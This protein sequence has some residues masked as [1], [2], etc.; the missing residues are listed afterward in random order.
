MKSFVRSCAALATT[1]FLAHCTNDAA[2]NPPPTAVPEAGVPSPAEDAGGAEASTPAPPVP[3]PKKANIVFILADDFTWNLVQYMPN[4]L[5]MQ[6]DGLTFAN[7]FV[8]D[9]LCCPSRTSIL[10]GMYPHDSGVFTNGG[11]DG[12]Y[13]TFLAKGNEQ[14]TF[15]NALSSTGY[16]TA[17]MGKYLNG[18]DPLSPAVPAGWTEWAG[19]GPGYK[20]FDY[21]LNQS[22]TVHHYGTAD[23]DYLT[24]VV[25]GLGGTF[26]GKDPGKP[27]LLEIAT[28]TP[29][30][31]YTPAPRDADA[32]PGLKAPRTSSYGAR[33]GPDAPTWLKAIPALTPNVEDKMDAAFRKRAQSV[34][35]IDKM[36]GTLRAAVAAAGQTDNTYFVF[37][38][39]NGYHMGEHSLRPGKQTAFDTDIHV[40]LI[41]VGPGVPAA[42]TASEIVQNIDLC[43]TFAELG[44]TPPP[45]TQTGRSLVPLLHGQSIADFRNAALV[46]HHGANFD[47]TDPDLPEADSGAPPTYAALRTKDAVYVEYTGGEIEYHAH[48]TDPYELQNTAA[49]LSV[50]QKAALHGTLTAL[51]N[52]HDAASCWSAQHV[53]PG[54]P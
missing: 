51:K 46:E 18:Y 1:L 37:S 54:A 25:A 36:I 13:A 52:C 2:S 42:K 40:P 17:L 3:A 12:G 19:A 49:S 41:V 7:Y 15:A 38:S 14:K 24:D 10:T 16:R 47:P 26:V 8:T 31:P 50:A 21:D 30:S 34:Q 32:F 48:T 28:F 43:S 33:P 22:G 53:L 27:F 9:S 35:A 29:H 23:A 45:P 5:Q 4:L 11:D 20:G 6:K 39:D 44:Q